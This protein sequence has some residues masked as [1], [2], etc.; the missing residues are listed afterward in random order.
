MIKKYYIPR[1]IW[2]DNYEN[3]NS[4]SKILMKFVSGKKYNTK[5]SDWDINCIKEVKIEYN[6]LSKVIVY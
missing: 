5:L 3:N 4:Q 6:K 1:G 2:I